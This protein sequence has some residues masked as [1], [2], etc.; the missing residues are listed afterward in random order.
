MFRIQDD[1]RVLISQF[2]TWQAPGCR[3]FVLVGGLDKFMDNGSRGLEKEPIV[4]IRKENTVTRRNDQT[5]FTVPSQ[6]FLAPL[7]GVL[8][9]KELAPTIEHD[10]RRLH[11]LHWTHILPQPFFFSSW[12][13]TWP[14]EVETERECDLRVPRI[15]RRT[16]HAAIYVVLISRT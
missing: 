11:R 4:L 7:L 5:P 14:Q 15:G 8:V 12:G 2:L 9:L 13:S 10:P 3:V 16:R 1:D 6:T